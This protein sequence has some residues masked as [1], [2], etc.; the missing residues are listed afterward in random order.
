MVFVC[1]CWKCFCYCFISQSSSMNQGA[2]WE[3]NTEKGC[4]VDDLMKLFYSL[5]VPEIDQVP[6][7]TACQ[8]AGDIPKCPL[9]SILFHACP[10]IL[11]RLSKAMSFKATRNWFHVHQ[12]QITYVWTEV[13]IWLPMCI[14]TKLV[15]IMHLAPITAMNSWTSQN[16]PLGWNSQVLKSRIFHP[17]PLSMF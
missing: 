13:N 2:S 6:N 9:E 3:Q 10:P 1:Q 17:Q 7:R 15:W 5:H 14:V 11:G 8:I 16:S 12:F 4:L